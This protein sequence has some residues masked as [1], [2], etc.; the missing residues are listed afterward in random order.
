MKKF[1]LFTVL[2]VVMSSCIT[3]KVYKMEPN[4]KVELKKPIQKKSALISSGMIAPLMDGDTEIFFFGEDA[5]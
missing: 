2:S 5:S 4:S 1:F 3:V